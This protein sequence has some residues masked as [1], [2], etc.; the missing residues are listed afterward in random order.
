MWA[1]KVA[2]RNEIKTIGG[3]CRQL[4]KRILADNL[5]YLRLDL[6]NNRFWINFNF[7]NSQINIRQEFTF[8]RCLDENVSELC[9]YY[10]KTFRKLARAKF[11]WHTM[12]F[13]CQ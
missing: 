1:L 2:M 3:L 12:S 5:A 7:R 9:R 10:F 8:Q 6:D 4:S 11:L 13:R